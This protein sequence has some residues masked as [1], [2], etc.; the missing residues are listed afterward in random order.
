MIRSVFCIFI[1]ICS[2][3]LQVSAQSCGSPLWWKG[4]L[5]TNDLAA[6]S[7]A[8]QKGGVQWPVI[9]SLTIVDTLK[10][11]E[12]IDGNVRFSLVEDLWK[13]IKKFEVTIG[14]SKAGAAIAVES[15]V[16]I[17]DALQHC[18]G[19]CNYVLVD[20]LNRIMLCRMC[21]YLVNE[22]NQWQQ[23][24][25]LRETAA[26]VPVTKLPMALLLRAET[27]GSLP[28]NSLE[29]TPE[30][31]WLDRVF[32]ISGASYRTFLSSTMSTPQPDVDSLLHHR[33]IPWLTFQMANVQFLENALLPMMF[34]FLEKGGRFE[35]IDLNDV[36]K[37]RM[38]MGATGGQQK[39]ELLHIRR[40]YSDQLKGLI[41]MFSNGV[42]KSSLYQSTG[43]H[44]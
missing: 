42:F 32:E 19:Y 25:A 35:D 4:Y 10:G 44:H 7:K 11:E 38:I 39:C 12:R 33:D 36:T 29:N 40:V 21:A 41:G 28:V 1:V 24:V 43:V 34:E 13:K 3:C 5:Q 27:D 9:D 20:A 37:F 8:L 6:I 26:F 15:Y 17:R 14:E 18:G 30:S 16:P 23:V 2:F 31:E 22:P